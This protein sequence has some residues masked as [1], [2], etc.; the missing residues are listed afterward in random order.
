MIGY[1]FFKSKMCEKKGVRCNVWLDYVGVPWY[2]QDSFERNCLLFEHI[3]LESQ[4]TALRL[5]KIENE[6]LTQYKNHGVENKNNEL[7]YTI[8]KAV[9]E[10][11]VDYDQ[12]CLNEIIKSRN[13]AYPFF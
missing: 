8:Q 3:L 4:G 1:Q 13:Y 7:V 5:Y 10:F 9:I 6:I 2:I 12:C 11:V